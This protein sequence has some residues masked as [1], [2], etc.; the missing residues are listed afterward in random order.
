M[1]TFNRSVMNWFGSKLAAHAAAAGLVAS[2]ALFS[3][4]A[5]AQTGEA[6]GSRRNSTRAGSFHLEGVSVWFKKKFT[7]SELETYQPEDFRIESHFCYCSDRPVPHYPYQLVFFST[8]KGDLVG[9]P[10]R[11]GFDTVITPLAER[12]GELYC[13]IDGEEDQCFGTFANPCEFTDFRYGKQLAPYF[14]SCKVIDPEP[15]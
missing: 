3:L 15:T 2:L 8:P 10:D 14:P 11:R 5:S 9:R 7:E 1:N 13:E 6:D 12:R 4:V